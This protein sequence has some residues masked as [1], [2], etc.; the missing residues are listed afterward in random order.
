V[1][2]LCLLLEEFLLFL[3]LLGEL[4]DFESELVLDGFEGALRFLLFF[5]YDSLVHLHSLPER[6][7]EAFLLLLVLGNTLFQSTG[8]CL[9]LSD[10]LVFLVKFLKVAFGAHN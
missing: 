6:V 2:D 4:F 1:N 9:E 3:F 7:F 5:S 8:L 10:F